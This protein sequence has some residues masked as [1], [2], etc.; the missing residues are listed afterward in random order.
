MRVADEDW[1]AIQEFGGA[2]WNK[3]RKRS[4]MGWAKVRQVFLLARASGW[5]RTDEMVK[6]IKDDYA[7]LTQTKLI[8]DGVRTE[9]VAEV[10]KG[11]NSAISG[12]RS[13]DE[14]IR[15]KVESVKHRFTSLPYESQALPKG[16]VSKRPT[17]L[18]AIQPKSAPANYKAIVSTSSVSGYY[19]AAPLRS[20]LPV[21]DMSLIRWCR[22]HDTL[23]KAKDSWLGILNVPCRLLLSHPSFEGGRWFIGL[24]S[25]VGVTVLGVPVTKV[26]VYGQEH[27][28]L[29][30]VNKHYWLPVLDPREWKCVPIAFRAPLSMRILCGKWVRGQACFIQATA[31]EDTLLRVSARFAFWDI[32]RTGLVTLAKEFGALVPAGADLPTL[33]MALCETI[34]GKLTDEDKL[35]IIRQRLPKTDTMKEFLM[36]DDAKECLGKDE[37]QKLQPGKDEDPTVKKGNDEMREAARAFAKKIYEKSAK[38]NT[39]KKGGSAGPAAKKARKYPNIVDLQGDQFTVAELNLYLPNGCKFGEDRLDCSWRLNAFGTRHSRAWNLYGSR[40]AALELMQLAWVAAVDQGF[41]PFCP[42][43]SFD[44]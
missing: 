21:E 15:D 43:E 29:D 37:L 39:G 6:V 13:W 42:F 8:E 4:T 24:R 26:R 23:D 44:L 17:A 14:L 41:E 22:E 40:G 25:H 16:I 20:S 35:K 19:S 34:L 1:A 3:V 36:T 27:F 31:D 10:N 11:F 7:G 2:F 18:F 5:T 33:L 28:V 38:A 30:E 12:P 32:P 9:R